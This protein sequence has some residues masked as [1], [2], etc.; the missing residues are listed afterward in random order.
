VSLVSHILITI[1]DT[2]AI[3]EENI[4]LNY[5]NVPKSILKSYIGE[6]DA[7]DDHSVEDDDE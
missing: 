4:V 5:R 2:I 3:I 1:E 7:D 6:E